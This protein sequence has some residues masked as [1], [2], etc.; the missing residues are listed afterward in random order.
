MEAPPNRAAWLTRWLVGGH[1]N[2]PT[3]LED[4]AVDHRAYLSG[5]I[6]EA[7]DLGLALRRHRLHDE[8]MVSFESAFGDDELH[9]RSVISTDESQQTFTYRLQHERFFEVNL[10]R[11]RVLPGAVVH[12]S[13]VSLRQSTCRHACK[14]LTSRQ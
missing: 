2:L 1:T 9:S 10:E 8:D 3:L 6:E 14:P 12:L 5:K 13:S 11:L 4:V 7:E